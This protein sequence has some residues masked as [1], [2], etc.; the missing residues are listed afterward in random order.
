MLELSKLGYRPR[1]EYRNNFIEVRKLAAEIEK[2]NSYLCRRIEVGRF[3][4]SGGS[5][6]SR[7]T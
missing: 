4:F 3:F 2:V 7:R 1:K 6:T 5:P